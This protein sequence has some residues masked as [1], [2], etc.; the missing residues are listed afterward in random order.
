M[1]KLKT[2]RNKRPTKYDTKSLSQTYS[3][4]T[5]LTAI[6][7]IFMKKKIPK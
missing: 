1:N 6:K 5:N 3:T 7:I 4:T 2:E